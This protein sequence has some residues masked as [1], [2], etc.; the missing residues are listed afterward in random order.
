MAL[1]LHITSLAGLYLSLH[2]HLLAAIQMLV[3][4]GA[5]VV[6]FV[7]VIMLIGPGALSSRPDERGVS[8]KIIG[9]ATIAIVAGTIAFQLGATDGGHVPII[10]CA[11][12]ATGCIEFGGVDA[13]SHAIFVDGAVPFE[14]ISILLLVA[15]IVAIAVARGVHPG[16]IGGVETDADLEGEKPKL[17]IRPR[18]ADPLPGESPAE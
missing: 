7:F 18:T 9:A 1:L 3:Y 5:V 10:S 17:P 6:L 13:L 15:I 2:A 14:L 4:A 8:I 12:G 11:E 16:E